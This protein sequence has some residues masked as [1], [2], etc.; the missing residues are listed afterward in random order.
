MEKDNYMFEKI[1]NLLGKKPETVPKGTV[2][3]DDLPTWLDEQEKDCITRRAEA[4]A[5]SRE[6]IIRFEGDIRQ[7]LTEFGEETSDE[8][9]HHKVEQVNRH[10]LPQFCKK[11][12]SELEGDF[13]EDDE[14]F[15]QEV[16][17]LM[18]GCFKAF[19]GP[20]RYLHHL[21]PEEIKAFRQTIDHMGHELNRMTEII[22]LSREHLA[23]LAGVRDELSVREEMM[24]E[25]LLA[26]EEKEKYEIQFSYLT[27]DLEKL[28]SDLASLTSS[29]EYKTYMHLEEDIRKA[30]E[31]LHSVSESYESQ[32]RNAIP[33][34]KRAGKIFQE[35]G[36]GEHE[37][38]MEDLVRL[39]SS[40]RRQDDEIAQKVSSSSRALFSLFDNNLLVTKNTFE[41]HLFTTP[42]EY[43]DKFT[44]V[45]Q[46]IHTISGDLTRKQ[47]EKEDNPALE[48]K[49]ELTRL[50]ESAEQKIHTMQE[51]ETRRVE[52]LSSMDE[53]LGRSLETIREKFVECA[54]E[55]VILEI[56]EKS[57][58]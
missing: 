37:K 36:D 8:P 30:E 25:S 44:Q 40:P 34:W 15:Y 48:K 4:I 19:K 7:L 53:K 56:P 45:I 11:I 2:S 51:E 6:R 22:R 42:D 58:E 50:I 39:A 24:K 3:L 41:K 26:S 10:A 27:R 23:R 17:G 33:V 43:A 29:A 20:G 12:E 35:Q 21:Y 57:D 54:G 46:S 47:K 5:T 16:A 1:R 32:I 55:G 38:L 31:Q 9:H 49:A 28:G 52:Q 13:S 18:D 14:A